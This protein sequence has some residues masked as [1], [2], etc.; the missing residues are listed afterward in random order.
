MFYLIFLCIFVLLTKRKSTFM[1]S[2]TCEYALR[3]LIC[4]ARKSRDGSRVGI[5]EIAAGIDSSEYFIAKILQELGRKDF[6][7]SA[8]GPNGGFYMEQKQ[9]G[10]SLADIVR[11]VDG[12]QLF[13]GCGLGLKQC[14]EQQPCPLHNEFK[15]IR[16][17]IKNM[18]E[19]SKIEMFTESLDLHLTFLRH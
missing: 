5:R 15:T 3:A 17:Q 2:K 16:N 12:D 8:K 6:V 1:F 18:L 11:E 4:I 10:I 14:S 7:Q 9:L 13:T 19:M